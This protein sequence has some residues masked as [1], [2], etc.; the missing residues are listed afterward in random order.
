M[1]LY[2]GSKVI[3][4]RDVMNEKSGSIGYVYEVY[5]R[6]DNTLGV[7][8][9]FQKGSYDGFSPEE[10]ELCLQFVENDSRFSM[11]EFNNV[12]QVAKDYREGYWRFHD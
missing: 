4:L 12:N 10:Q 8:V 6:G 5:E 9:I 1:E 7:S 3:L 11:Y 2:V